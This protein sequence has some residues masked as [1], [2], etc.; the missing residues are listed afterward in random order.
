MKNESDKKFLILVTI[1]LHS[2]A[3]MSAVVLATG[4]SQEMLFDAVALTE[5]FFIGYLAWNY[6]TFPDHD[7]AVKIVKRTNYAMA[8]L[9]VFSWM[10]WPLAHIIT[11][12]V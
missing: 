8:F 6:V 1:F 11:G 9:I 10:I 7:R 5:P 3:I 12:K 4:R 2:I